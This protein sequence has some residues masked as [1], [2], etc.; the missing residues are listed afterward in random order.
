LIRDFARRYPEV[1]LQLYLSTQLADLRRGGLDVAVRGSSQIE[2]GL[3]ARVLGKSDMI[4]V[5]SPA[6]L[7]QHGT[8]RTVR[9]LKRHRCLVGFARG[10]LPQTHW[11]DKRGRKVQVEASLASNDIVLL[12]EMALAGLG[13]AFCLEK[14]VRPHIARGALKQ[15]LKG[16]LH[17]ESGMYIVYP[18]REYLPP[19]VRA[20]VDAFTAWTREEGDVALYP[21]P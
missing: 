18:E 7:A 10:E 3:V 13:I 9:E 11:T 17:G 6:Y 5:A 12:K 1:R 16:S 19:Q 2:P 15:V 14:M 20:F 4:A 21:A 8:P